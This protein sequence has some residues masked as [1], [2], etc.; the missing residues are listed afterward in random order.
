MGQF[1]NLFIVLGSFIAV[2]FILYRKIPLLLELRTDET[3][4]KDVI[5]E[6]IRIFASTKKIRRDRVFH[7]TLSK[8]RSLASKTETHTSELLEKLKKKSE[9]HKEDFAESYWE[10]LRKKKK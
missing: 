5:Q 4:M 10:Q 6:G 1:I 8:A 3:T 7:S 2:V 9:T